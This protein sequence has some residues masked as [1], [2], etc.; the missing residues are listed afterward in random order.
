[1]ACFAGAQLEFTTEHGIEFVTVGD[2]GNR[3]TRPEEGNPLFADVHQPRG[4]VAYEY[5]IARTE[6]TLRQYVEFVEAYLPLEIERTGRVLG[7]PDFAGRGI[8]TDLGGA[9][10]RG[11]HSPN[12][13]ADMSWEYAARYVNWLH[14]GKVNE[15]WAFDTGAYD[16]STFTQNPDGTYN[17]QVAHSP[18]ARFWIPTQDEWIKAAYWDPQKDDGK[19]GYWLYPNSSDQ[20]SRPGLL[21]EEGGE[22]NAGPGELFPLDVRSFEDVHEICS[23]VVDGAGM[24][25]AAYLEEA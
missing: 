17:H 4:A 6:V 16:T 15:P 13:A 24:N 18:D 7:A 11:G 5:R 1:M 19:G 3:P 2:P 14:N 8:T 25:K 9:R 20:E 12:Q 22:R 10:I 23:K 21:P